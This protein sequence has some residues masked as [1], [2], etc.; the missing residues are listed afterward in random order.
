MINLLLADDHDIMLD[1]YTSI[2]SSETN[3]KIVGR[4]NNGREV[5]TAL[6]TDTCDVVMLDINMPKMDGVET[7]RHLKKYKPAIKIIIL[8]MLND[9]AYIKELVS[10]GIDGYLLKNC[11]KRTFV[12]AINAVARGNTFFDE[13]IKKVIDSGYK[14]D[15]SVNENKVVLSEREIEIVRMIALGMTSKQIADELFLSPH[16]VQTHRKNINFKLQISNPVELTLFAK[17]QGLIPD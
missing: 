1:G 13:T 9:I 5:I 14:A 3:I 8:S 6:E 15:F 7:A 11:D 12:T 2:L 4:A 10:I 16:T 17:K